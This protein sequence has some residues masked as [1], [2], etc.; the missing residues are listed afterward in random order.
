[1]STPLWILL[2]VAVFVMLAY[3]AVMRVFFQR[4]R[5]ADKRVDYTKI[6]P[7]KDEED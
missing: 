4:S 5:E 6:R 7:W 3:F 2:A 1:M